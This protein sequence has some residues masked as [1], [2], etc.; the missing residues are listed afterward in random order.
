[1]LETLRGGRPLPAASVTEAA[2]RIDRLS[3]PWLRLRPWRGHDTCYLRALLHYRFL[4]AVGGEKRLHL[5]VEPGARPGDPPRGHAWVT[6]DGRIVDSEMAAL[7]PRTREIYR[8]P[9]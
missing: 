9:A 6:V 1:M 3:G 2:A 4:D 8:H 7:A 5:A